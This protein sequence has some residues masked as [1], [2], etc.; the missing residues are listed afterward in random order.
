MNS[1]VATRAIDNATAGAEMLDRVRALQ[2][3][4]RDNADKTRQAR[5]LPAENVEALQEAGFFLAL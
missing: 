2:P 1:P 5:R 4:F 3:L